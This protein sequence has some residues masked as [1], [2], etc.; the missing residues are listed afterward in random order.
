MW[1]FVW[2][3]KMWVQRI[4]EDHL[5]KNKKEKKQ[6]GVCRTNRWNRDS[7]I[8][9]RKVYVGNGRYRKQ[10]KTLIREVNQSVYVML[11]ERRVSFFLWSYLN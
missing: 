1:H 7:G 9:R 11:N 6:D 4:V 10:P 8:S 5:E 2:E 3:K